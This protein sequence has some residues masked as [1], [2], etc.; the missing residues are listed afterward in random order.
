MKKGL[1]SLLCALACLLLTQDVTAV[2]FRRP[3]TRREA[4]RRKLLQS[5]A[6]ISQKISDMAKESNSCLLTN[7]IN[8]SMFLRCFGTGYRILSQKY[9][10]YYNELSK[11]VID[12]LTKGMQPLCVEMGDTC[13]NFYQSVKDTMDKNRNVT[14]ELRLL[15]VETFQSA[16]IPKSDLKPIVNALLADYAQLLSARND[17]A[18]KLGDGIKQIQNYI[19][20]T[21]IKP[22]FDYRTVDQ[23]TAL[24]FL[25]IPAVELGSDDDGDLDVGSDPHYEYSNPVISDDDVS[26]A[27]A[28]IGL[29]EE[30]NQVANTNFGD[31]SANSQ[32]K[33]FAY[34]KKLNERAGRSF[35]GRRKR[36]V[37][38]KNRFFQSLASEQKALGQLL[39][40]IGSARVD[41]KSLDLSELPSVQ[42]DTII[43]KG[44]A[45]KGP[46]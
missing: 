7:G 12:D 37:V 42:V 20:K 45:K 19:D 17:M 18:K 16:P 31:E 22:D 10:D 38:N 35:K 25:T 43:K 9:M 46:K 5:A 11:T 44:L 4:M 2:T 34:A 30:G 32:I 36:I 41:P 26:S 24:A 40:Y 15:I 8:M 23:S 33:T 14:P 39:F 13:Y 1:I 27:V 29:D 28:Y 3:P 6:A 21:G